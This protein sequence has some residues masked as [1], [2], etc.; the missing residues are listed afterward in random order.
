MANSKEAAPNAQIDFRKAE[1]FAEF[2]ANNVQLFSS[3]WDLRLTFGHLDP[4]IGPNAVV[5]ETAIT[6][7]W[8]QAKV[9]L[10]YLLSHLAGQEAEHGHVSVPKNVIPEI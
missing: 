7:P 6:V 10:F 1:D 2:Y 9:M 8:P 3:A 5:Q 4:S